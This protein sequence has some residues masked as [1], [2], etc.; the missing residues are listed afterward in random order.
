MWV[1]FVVHQKRKEMTDLILLMGKMMPMEMIAEEIKEASTE[2]LLT[3]SEES[4]KKLT[5]YSV[6]LATK[7]AVGD[8][9]IDKL[10]KDLEETKRIQERLNSEKA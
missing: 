3:K 2:Y 4:K 5:M 9:D 8:R 1:K 10:S 6:L 7:E